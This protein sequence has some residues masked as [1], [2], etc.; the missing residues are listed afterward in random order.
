MFEMQSNK[1][2]PNYG[3]LGILVILNLIVFTIQMLF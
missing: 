2:I 1:K 3:G